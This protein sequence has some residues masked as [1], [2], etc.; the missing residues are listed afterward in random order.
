MVDLLTKKAVREH[1]DLNVGADVY[2]ALEVELEEL[3]EDAQAR[4]KANDR[5]TVQAHDL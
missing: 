3:L 4:A 2:E 5:K 1:T